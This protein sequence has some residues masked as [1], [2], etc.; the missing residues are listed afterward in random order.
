MTV[1]VHHIIV[2]NDREEIGDWAMGIYL[3]NI[4]MDREDLV[5]PEGDGNE[6]LL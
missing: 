5:E 6:R 4:P 2:E 3:T 1:A